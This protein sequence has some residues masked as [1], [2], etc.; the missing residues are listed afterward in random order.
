MRPPQVGRRGFGMRRASQKA[1]MTGQSAVDGSYPRRV[2]SCLTVLGSGDVIDYRLLGPLEV[3]VDGQVVDVGG[4]K[5]RALLTIL[6]LHV[7]QPVHRDALIDRL[8][9]ERPP[10]GA[11]H[12]V[13]VYISRLRKALE[14]AAGTQEVL[15]R[16]GGYLLQTAPEQLDV[17][18][19]ERL[20]EDGR[21]SLAAGDASCA[22]Q[23]FGAA[24]ALCRGETLADF[25]HEPFAQAE[26]ARL[27][28]L[29]A[30]VVED[31]IEADLALGNHARVAGELERRSSSRQAAR[32][33]AAVW[34][35]MTWRLWTTATRRRSNRFLR[36][37]R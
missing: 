3:A 32:S 2:P 9:G 24:L 31:R 17:A 18:R 15:T 37:P 16:P 22:A 5:Q 28:G 30:A 25:Q 29:R 14:K 12:A 20:A 21:R 11:E 10:S 36:V 26:I 27:D 33:S 8:W 13:D 23:Q 35:A 6:L 4:L 7:N 19:F 34:R 1:H